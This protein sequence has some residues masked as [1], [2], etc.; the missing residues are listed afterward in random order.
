MFGRRD[1]ETLDT[2]QATCLREEM[3]QTAIVCRRE[4][5]VHIKKRGRS[6]GEI[7]E[8][9]CTSTL[10]QPDEKSSFCPALTHRGCFCRSEV[11]R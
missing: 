3:D 8:Q 1:T 11:L 10:T 9:T 6:A 4:H 2:G 5:S 7:S